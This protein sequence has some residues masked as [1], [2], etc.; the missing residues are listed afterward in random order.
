MRAKRRVEGLLVMG[1]ERSDEP[2]A[3]M[4]SVRPSPS[5]HLL[6]VPLD[7]LVP[8]RPKPVGTVLEA[9][10]P[11]SLDLPLLQVP[12]SPVPPVPELV[13]VPHNGRPRGVAPAHPHHHLLLYPEVGEG[14]VF[15][16]A[17]EGAVVTLV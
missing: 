11:A 8:V 7:D 17:L 14:G 12:V 15:V 4:L 3:N 10:P 1:E 2:I 5:P 16:V 13:F 9:L 6:K